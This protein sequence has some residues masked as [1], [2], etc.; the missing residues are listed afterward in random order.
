MENNNATH[1]DGHS[2]LELRAAA[3]VANLKEIGLSVATAESCTGGLIAA[4]LTTV[5]H[6][7]ANFRYGWVTYCN[8]AKCRELGVRPDTIDTF[9]VVSENVVA[10]M[11]NGAIA[12]SG[13]DCGIAVSGNAGPTAA[14]GE[15]PVGTVCIALARRGHPTYTETLFRPD[16]ERNAFRNMVAARALELISQLR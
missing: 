5:P 7:S 13:S 10:E 8:E 4:M 6:V 12:K 9:T 3:A 14:E 15:P 11:A 16:L 2:N 1:L